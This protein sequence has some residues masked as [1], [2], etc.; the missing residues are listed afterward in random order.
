MYYLLYVLFNNVHT[1]VL[2]YHTQ[3]ISEIQLNDTLTYLNVITNISI[4]ETYFFGPLISE[5]QRIDIISILNI[6]IFN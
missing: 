5:I 6:I 2:I 1:C 3:Y 4:S